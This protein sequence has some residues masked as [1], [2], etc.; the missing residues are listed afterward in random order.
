MLGL[1]RQKPNFELSAHGKHPAF[2]DYFSLNTDLPLVKALSGWIEK[3]IKLTGKIKENRMSHSFRFWMRGIKKNEL[4]LGIIR[5][6]SDRLGRPYPLLIMGNGVVR[7]WEKRWSYIFPGFETVYR[8][9]EDIAASR[10]ETFKEL[11]TKLDRIV[12]PVMNLDHTSK[13]IDE[14][15]ELPEIMEAWFKKD[16]EKG[17][18]SLPVA[19]LL[20][21]GAAPYSKE[22]KGPGLFKKKPP[23]P[24]AVFLG[25]LPQNSV[26]TMYA[27]PLKVN[28]FLSLF[29]ISHGRQNAV[30]HQIQ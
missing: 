15:S 18:L 29:N 16:R 10:Y 12:F 25:G 17:E 14:M 21:M 1:G 7:N 23:V 26:L 27:R 4:A 20:N 28:D 2:S 13:T 22:V 9:F 5:E 6:S 19:R 8:A 11:E 24:G 30:G 3:G